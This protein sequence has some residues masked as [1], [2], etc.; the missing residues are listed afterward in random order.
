MNQPARTITGRYGCQG[1]SL[2]G[3]R[4][5]GRSERCLTPFGQVNATAGHLPPVVVVTLRPKNIVECITTI[6][7]GAPSAGSWS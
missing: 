2:G 1:Q 3:L 7:Q 4:A 6:T 5:A